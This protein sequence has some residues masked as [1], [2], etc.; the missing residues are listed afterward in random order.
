[1]KK[2]LALFLVVV[3][4]F[5]LCACANDK[6]EYPV[7]SVVTTSVVE[8]SLSRFEYAE[9]L[10]NATFQTGKTPDP[11]YLLPTKENQYNNPFVADDGKIMISF[12]YTI[13]NISKEK[14]TF[15]VNLGIIADYN[16]GY[17]FTAYANLIK[18]DYVILTDTTFLD[19]LSQTCEGRGYIEVPKE[20]MDN[21]SA[22]LFI[23]IRLPN[24]SNNEKTTEINY[25]IR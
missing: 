15:P 22:P 20:V 19:P 13:K 14:L 5:S 25:K 8:F 7:G 4:C 18:G 11:E 23:K 21:E 24:D 17:E 10:K 2:F 6:T 3:L 16:D 1:M 12:S 9:K